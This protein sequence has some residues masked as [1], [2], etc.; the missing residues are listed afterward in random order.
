VRS[1]Q[2]SRLFFQGGPS[3]TGDKVPI[4][5]RSILRGGGKTS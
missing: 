4:S 5:D 3:R 2:V 1:P